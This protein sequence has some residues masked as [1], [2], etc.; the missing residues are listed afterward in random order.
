MM[1]DTSIL[2]ISTPKKFTASI[3]S[4]KSNKD[5]DDDRRA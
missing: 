3:S 2:E 4:Y 5:D 1:L